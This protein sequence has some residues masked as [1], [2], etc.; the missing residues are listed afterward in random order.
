[1]DYISTEIEQLTRHNRT[2]EPSRVCFS[3]CD[4]Y[5]GVIQEH[6][7][8]VL[9]VRR[10]HLMKSNYSPLDQSNRNSWVRL[11]TEKEY[12]LTS[13]NTQNCV[14]YLR[15]SKS[16]ETSLDGSVEWFTNWCLV[17]VRPATRCFYCRGDWDG[18]RNG[19]QFD[20]MATCAISISCQN[21]NQSIHPLVCLFPALPT[22]LF[23]FLVS[24]GHKWKFHCV[25]LW[26]S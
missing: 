6:D 17:E 22:C 3:S 20:F 7:G 9:K 15:F 13:W 16:T 24:C 12:I 19:S 5:A 18:S 21:S 1:M 4:T 14:S 25:E 2:W 8:Y 23:F 11:C 10:S 26:W